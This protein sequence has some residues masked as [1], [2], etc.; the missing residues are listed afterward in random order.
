MNDAENLCKLLTHLPPGVF[1]TFMVREFGV[2]L[3]DLD[4]RL[5][6]R[7]QRESME[8]VLSAMDIR[9]RQ[10][11]EETAERIVLLSD[12]PGQDVIDGISRDVFDDQ[13]RAVFAALRNQY[14]RALWL[15]EHKSALFETAINGRQA[16]VFKQSSSC[17]SGFL[18]PKNLCVLEDDQARQA[19]HQAMAEYLGCENSAVAVQVF[20]R[21]HPD[22]Q[23]G[24]DVELYQVSVHHNRPPE[25]VESVQ[26]SELVPQEVVRAVSLHITYEPPHGF[27][28]VLSKGSDGREAIAV[29]VADLLLK[30][31]ITGEKI[32]IKQYDYQS[33]AAPR[34]LDISGDNV[35]S[36][37]VTELGYSTANHRSMLVKIWSRDA[38]DIY[39]AA[40]ELITP[41]FDF[42]HHRLNYVKLSIRVKK[43]GKDRA[44]TIYVI[45]REDNQCNIKSKRE[46]DRALCDRLLAKWKLVKEI[47]HAPVEAVAA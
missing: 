29:M 27:L 18:V 19:F 30:S 35:D 36:V 20:K 10:R 6:K 4:S 3:P 28:E 43:D 1:H 47:G 31:P 14:E 2:A 23:T 24:E 38:D 34:S 26:D 33:L 21:I 32:P 25:F 42:R 5:G 44:R 46:K 7:K 22:S 12:G 37:K 11:I 13:E 40:R 41:T 9:S 45:L 17:H 16:D 15:Y 39:V 8:S